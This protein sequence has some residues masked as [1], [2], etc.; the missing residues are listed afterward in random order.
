MTCHEI[1]TLLPGHLEGV[2]STEE[3]ETIES[4]LASCPLC[5]RVLE[6]LKKTEYLVKGLSEVEPP[7]F[8]EQRI[9]A[10]IRE[11]A[12]QKKGILRKFF[13]PLHIK[14]PIQAMATVL[15]AVFAFYVF[16]K[17]QPEIG[18][19][20]PLA[21]P[22]TES[23]KGRI[24]DGSIKTPLAP[25]V[26]KPATPAPAGDLAG[27]NY[28]PFAAAP[29]SESKGR[30]DRKAELPPPEQEE[31]F[32]T[33]K[34]RAPMMAEREKE[35]PPPSAQALG[36][37]QDRAEKQDSGRALDTL[38]TE[39]KQKGRVT[40]PGVTAGE[41]RV[42]KSAPAAS[43]FAAGPP[44]KR[45]AVELTIQVRDTNQAVKEIEDRL[46]QVN[47]RVIERRHQEGRVFLKAEITGQTVA[48]FLDR[49]A[50]VGKITSEQNPLDYP[51]GKVTVSIKIV[52]SP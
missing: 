20:T 5:R 36:K 23:H 9:M 4:H 8:F 52:T 3:K 32:S 49:L 22:R 25:S 51:E 21:I 17:S 44:T 45:F 42:M 29:S 26:A 30:V 1:K 14:I 38:G 37:A 31:A 39:Q 28:G 6:D 18:Q 34:Q 2:L 15:I 43:R 12:V 33:I 19:V 41:S 24:M 35:V 40:E 10:M 13:Y 11:E 47:G 50:T 46:A 16:Q 7:P 27:K 48:G